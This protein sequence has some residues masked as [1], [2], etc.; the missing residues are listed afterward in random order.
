MMLECPATATQTI[1]AAAASPTAPWQGARPLGHLC[2][3]DL[4]SRSVLAVQ[5]ACASTSCAAA[6]TLQKAVQQCG[7]LQARLGTA[8]R[9]RGWLDSPSSCAAS[10]MACTDRESLCCK[11]GPGRRHASSCKLHLAVLARP[12]TGPELSASRSTPPVLPDLGCCNALPAQWL[13]FC[14]P[15][16]GRARPQSS[17][18]ARLSQPVLR[19]LFSRHG[20]LGK[21]AVCLAT[22][23]GQRAPGCGR[24]AV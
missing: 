3:S 7:Q 14:P 13:A 16:S 1:R 19:E 23:N 2:F 4:L 24:A 22:C 6:G 11:A 10:L 5:P 17:A 12:Q 9:R 20:M 15:C 18:C 8:G 21:M